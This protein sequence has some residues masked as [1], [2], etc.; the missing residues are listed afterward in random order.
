MTFPLVPWPTSVVLLESAGAPADAPVEVVTEQ[1]HGEEGYALRIEAGAVVIRASSPAGVFYA[2]QTLAQ[3]AG[4]DELPAVDIRDRPRFAHRGMMLD[5]ARHFHPVSTVEAVIDRAASLKLNVLHLHLTDD[6]GWRL[7]LRSHPE[8]AQSASGTSVGGDP[9][10]HYSID[11][12]MHIVEYAAARHMTVVPEFDLPGHTHAIGLSHPELLAEPVITDHIREITETYGG[13]GLPEQGVPYTALAVGFSSFQA[14]A[15]GLETFL[16]EVLGEIAA[17]T[18][19]PYL[20]IGGDE[21]LGTDP[22][23]Y[24]RMVEL[25]TRIVAEADKTPVTWHEAGVA[26]LPPGTVGQ[27]WG[28]RRP[29]LEGGEEGGEDARR[30]RSFAERGGRVVLSPA[31]AVYLDMK[32]EADSRLGLV[33]ADGPTSLARSYDWDPATVVPG[34]AEEAILG[35]EAC[36]WTETIRTPADVDEMM[37]PRVASAAEA[38]WS[39]RA[40]SPERT[41]ES[42]RE[43]VAGLGDRWE[44]AG[45]GFHRSAGVDW[46]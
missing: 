31:D 15:E 34:L 17:L 28:F 30:A 16:R 23:D 27:Y 19:G 21:A 1:G 7:E 14:D 10:G 32:H 41:W 5:V 6:H 11:D 46:R 45:I 42:F 40:G 8:L 36:M 12:Y 39:E 22:A 29:S 26:D 44:A 33:W 2:R 35:V 37:F 18:P 3:L 20:H 38:A 13:G 25:A 4:P 9:G 24:R 43:R